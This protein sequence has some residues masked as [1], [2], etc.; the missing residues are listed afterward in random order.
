[1]RQDVATR[2]SELAGI[3]IDAAT[4]EQDCQPAFSNGEDDEVDG[5]VE[6]GHDTILASF[7]RLDDIDLRRLASS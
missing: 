5:D 4:H 7:R 2:E 6:V 3:R 1:V